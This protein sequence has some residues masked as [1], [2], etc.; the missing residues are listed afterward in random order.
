MLL[1]ILPPMFCSHRYHD[2]HHRAKNQLT[3]AAK[4]LNL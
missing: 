2:N 4:S 1:C 3:P